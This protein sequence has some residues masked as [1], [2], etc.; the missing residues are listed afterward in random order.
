MKP[1]WSESDDLQL[2]AW[3]AEGM[4]VAEIARRL[5]RSQYAVRIY[6]YRQGIHF[7]DRRKRK[8]P[9]TWLAVLKLCADGRGRTVTE[10]A[11]A[12]QMSGSSVRSLLKARRQRG[13]AC[14]CGHHALRD[15]REAALWLPTA[16]AQSS[17]PSSAQQA[18]APRQHHPALP[19]GN[20]SRRSGPAQ[21]HD[22]VRALFG[23]E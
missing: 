11:K 9:S 7:E 15:G 12:R 6:A 18:E 22:I 4:A 21:Q 20:A 23:M 3:L 19:V 1:S 10:I 14:V 17:A 5:N 2:R 13:L 16:V 8:E